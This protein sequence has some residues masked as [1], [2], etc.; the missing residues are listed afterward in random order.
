[1]WGG[2]GGWHGSMEEARAKGGWPRM[3][4]KFFHGWNFLA[5]VM[6]QELE[7]LPQPP[8]LWPPYPAGA[9]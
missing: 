2:E 8:P 5:W 6:S 3:S 7:K 9:F 4:K 1:V